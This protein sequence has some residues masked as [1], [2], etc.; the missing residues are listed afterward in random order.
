[1]AMLPIGASTSIVDL[2]TVAGTGHSPP[3]RAHGDRHDEAHHPVGHS[4]H[5]LGSKRELGT[6]GSTRSL[7]ANAFRW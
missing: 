2:S 3:C 5:N 7:A 6:T 4:L 1:V